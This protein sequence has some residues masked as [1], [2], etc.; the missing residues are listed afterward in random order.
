MCLFCSSFVI[1]GTADELWRL[2]SF[3]VFAKA[4]LNYLEET[5]GAERTTDDLLEDLRDRYRVA[6]PYVDD[7]TRRQFATSRV[8]EARAKTAAALHPYWEHQMTMSRRARALADRQPVA[9]EQNNTRI[10][11]R[12]GT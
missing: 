10:G 7:L 8:V 5:L 12:F 9:G 3:Q 4:E 2:F 1:A 6:V 11:E